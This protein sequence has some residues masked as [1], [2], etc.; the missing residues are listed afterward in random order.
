MPGTCRSTGIDAKSKIP[1]T[2]GSLLARI[3]ASGLHRTSPIPFHSSTSSHS[4]TSPNFLHSSLLSSSIFSTDLAYPTGAS[5]SRRSSDDESEDKSE[6][7]PSS[8]CEGRRE[9][10]ITSM[11]ERRLL[12]VDLA[13][14][15]S[16]KVVCL[17]D[18]GVVTAGALFPLGVLFAF[19][20]DF[21]GGLRAAI[22]VLCR[23]SSHLMSCRTEADLPKWLHRSTAGG[24]SSSRVSAPTGGA[25]PRPHT[26]KP[27]AQPTGGLES[28]A[29]GRMLKQ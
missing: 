29:T 20:G 19:A 4:A 5:C 23:H 25:T 12:A 11:I 2:N 28:S 17:A 7:S 22:A 10:M 13:D 6:S 14:A 18:F 27:D 16:G 8:L 1:R 21:G 26:N 3:T 9:G 24:I 15:S